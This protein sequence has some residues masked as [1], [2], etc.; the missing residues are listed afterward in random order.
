MNTPAQSFAWWCVAN[1]GIAPSTL[2]AGAAK[3][4]YTGVDFLDEELWP[5]ARDHGLS[6]AAIAGHGT[7]EDG[8]NRPENATRI[9]DELHVN[10][11]KAKRNGIRV[12]ICFSGNRRGQNDAAGLECCA[13]NLANIAPVAEA[14]GVTLAMELLNS[15]FDH[16][17]YQA[18]HTAWGVEL[19]ERVGS[20]A[21]KLLYDIYH[22]QIMEGDVI[23]TI[24]IHHRAF[25]HYH[26][27][28]NPGRGPLDDGQELFFPAIFRAIARTGYTGFIGHEFHPR[29]DV[30]AELADAAAITRKA[31][32]S[33]APAPTETA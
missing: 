10:I 24:E 29:K 22:M 17:D 6:P 11:E 3:A 31:F 20:P 8:L 33:A 5:L 4:G 25:G 18:D 2:L 13:Q 32:A 26:T 9:L 16:K 28:G 14:A 21:V 27:A 1:R 12:L 23:R 15:R 30:L 19:C 7:L